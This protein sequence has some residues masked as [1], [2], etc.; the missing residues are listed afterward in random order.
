M[1]KK[2]LRK[3]YK[4]FAAEK[5]TS[6]KNDPQGSYTGTP[7]DEKETPVQDADDL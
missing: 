6:P 2:E 5:M 7:A 4:P 1:E 3:K